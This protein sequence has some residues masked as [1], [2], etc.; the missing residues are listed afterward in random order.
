MDSPIQDAA[1]LEI[2]RLAQE[3]D[4]LEKRA[5]E[6]EA[7]LSGLKDLDVLLRLARVKLE[8]CIR[9]ME[10]VTDEEAAVK[11]REKAFA[12]FRIVEGLLSENLSEDQRGAVAADPLYAPV[13]EALEEFLVRGGGGFLETRAET[14][15]S[16][17]AISRAVVASIRKYAGEDDRY[18][19]LILENYPPFVQGV[20]RF[21]FPVM[22]HEN[23]ERPPYGI[24]EGEETTTSSPRMKLPLSQAI[25]YME[26][27]LLPELQDR[28]E[29][30]PWDAGL[31]EQIAS[32][33][34][35]VEEYRKLRFF[36]RSTPVLLEKDFYTQGMTF[37]TPDG[38]LLVPIPLPVTMRSGTNLDRKMELVR[39]DLV[40]RLA[41]R[42]LCPP[43]DDEYRRLRSLESGIRGSSRTA[44]LKL[45]SR[46]GFRAL[47]QA[48]PSL[49]RL[50]DKQEFL[51]LAGLAASGSL[52]ACERRV[53]ALLEK[54]RHTRRGL[55]GIT[56]TF[57]TSPS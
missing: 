5:G 16:T 46:S 1:S 55:P 44:S 50:E 15:R 57:G 30:A 14:P 36:P 40:R 35:Q 45:D 41:G 24:E 37:Y 2:A 25:F 19:P 42:G 11:V 23:P 33:E 51:E 6:I 48:F 29:D 54:D 52:A 53:S 10:K 13:K 8:L 27:E 22:I 31:Q 4:R 38:E 49:S 17:R 3:E 28:L 32:V 12:A 21:L 39:A 26:N 43:L 20:L 56:G 9:L 34:R 7:A 47:K 18:P